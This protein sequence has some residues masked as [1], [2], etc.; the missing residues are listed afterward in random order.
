MVIK[1]QDVICYVNYT[2][3]IKPDADTKNCL[4]RNKDIQGTFLGLVFN[5][6]DNPVIFSEKDDYG[7]DSYEIIDLNERFKIEQFTGL[8][9]KHHK[10][11]YESDNNDEFIVYTVFEGEYLYGQKWNGIGEDGNVY[12][13]NGFKYDSETIYKK[14][15]KVLLQD[16]IDDLLAS[17]G[18]STESSED[19]KTESSNEITQSEIYSLLSGEMPEEKKEKSNIS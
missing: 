4:Y 2:T 1:W 17:L 10:E 13:K 5:A 11:I 9:D 7:T 18:D 6:A 8:Y 16:E 19:N 14:K 3:K 15:R 12:Y